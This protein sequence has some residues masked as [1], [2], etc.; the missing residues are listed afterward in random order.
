M[1]ANL[2]FVMNGMDD[3]RN[4]FSVAYLAMLYRSIGSIAE[5]SLDNSPTPKRLYTP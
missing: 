3:S 5:S 1:L 4:S 2:T